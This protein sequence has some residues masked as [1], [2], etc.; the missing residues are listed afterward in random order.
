MSLNLQN[1]D[2]REA[3]WEADRSILLNLRKLV[4]IVEQKVPVS[5]EFDGLDHASW[6]WLVD[7]KQGRPIGTG[8]LLNSGQI[9]RMAVLGEHR[10]EG[11]GAA[12]LSTI[13]EKARTLGFEDIFLNAQVH[14]VGFY[15]KAGFVKSGAQFEEAG[16]P[17]QRMTQTLEPVRYEDQ[18]F[19]ARAT[20][21]EA[22]I[23][24]F[25]VS[26]ANWDADGKIIRKV[27]ESVTL[28][29]NE[30]PSIGLV[31]TDSQDVD[32]LH[33]QAQ[34]SDGQVIGS[35]RM[36]PQGEISHL[37]VLESFRGL[38]VGFSLVEL[39]IIRARQL[40]L[41]IATL[42]APAIL[43]G[44][45]RKSGFEVTDSR[46]GVDAD[47]HTNLL[48]FECKLER[49][50]IAEERRRF[51]K[52]T[53]EDYDASEKPYVLGTSNQFLLL[54]REEEFRNVIHEMMPQASQCIRIWSPLLDHR[55]FH[56]KVLRDA[57]SQLAR[58]N[59]YTKIEILIYDA[60]RIIKNTHEILEISRRLP[61][62]IG[63]KIVHP[64]FRVMNEEFV[65][66][67]NAGVIYRQDA[68]NYEGYANFRDVTENNRLTR[69]FRAAWNTGL[70]DP[71]I[72]QLK[73]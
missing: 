32:C 27:R 45:F 1:F 25:D 19:G 17:H 5:E 67:D 52:L 33:W 28:A 6:H 60:H 71:N 64:E 14:A 46:S 44:F 2:I 57:L 22:G 3:D 70:L 40:N 20:P 72:R 34:S 49:I 10:G 24:P 51:G 48:S 12:L 8:R 53:G 69:K 4:F 16:I 66:V 56:S 47:H 15:S 59:R 43:Q 30:L 50:D 63:I 36:T 37:A 68:E 23:R 18:Q 39:A 26:E 65:L 54:R 11:I 21:L 31:G 73:I 9:G 42:D 55:L 7:D 35:I 58:K 62:S 38:G 29:A 13:I 61:S 41:A